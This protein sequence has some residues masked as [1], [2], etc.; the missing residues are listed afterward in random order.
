M[1]PS[2]ATKLYK[3][4]KKFNNEKLPTVLMYND[5]NGKTLPDKI[6]V[7]QRR[8][9]YFSALLINNEELLCEGQQLD[10]QAI[11]T[12]EPPPQH[13]SNLTVY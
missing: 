3:E 6:Q 13:M 4:I 10:L 1:K 9:E 2:I 5:V 11:D 12:K 7:L 8:K